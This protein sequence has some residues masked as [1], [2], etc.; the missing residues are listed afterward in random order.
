MNAWRN[1]H[2]LYSVVLFRCVGLLSVRCEPV[3]N[4]KKMI[5][6]LPC[7]TNFGMARSICPEFLQLLHCWR[8]VRALQMYFLNVVMLSERKR[9]VTSKTSVDGC[10]YMHALF[11]GDFVFHLWISRHFETSTNP[12]EQGSIPLPLLKEFHH[13]IRERPS[14]QRDLH[15]FLC[16]YVLLQGTFARCPRSSLT[17]H[18]ACSWKGSRK[19]I[20]LP[21]VLDTSKLPELHYAQKAMTVNDNGALVHPRHKSHGDTS[22][23]KSRCLVTIR[24]EI[25]T[26]C[27]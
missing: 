3:K 2:Q 15:T 18:P 19:A 11:W 5:S 21:C 14:Q 9:Q 16:C 7:D 10:M 6:G 12:L 25:R 26:E 17:R 13:G 27:R 23:I 4:V 1:N 22:W 24:E 20:V 8:S